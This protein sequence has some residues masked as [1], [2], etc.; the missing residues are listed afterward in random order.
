MYTGRF[1][2][3]PT[4]PLHIGSLLTALASWLW[5]HHAGGA[6]LVRIEDTDPPREPP[7]A[8]LSILASL[9]AHGLWHPTPVLWQSTRCDAYATA[10]RQL[11]DTGEAFYCTCSRQDLATGKHAVACAQSNELPTEPAAVRV[12]T[13]AG[14]A[15]FND[16]ILGR[17]D[18]PQSADSFVVQR[19]DG[20]YAYHLAVVVDDAFQQINHVVRGRDLLDSTPLH[21]RLQELLGLPRPAYAHLPLLLNSEGQKLS[22]Q[23]HATALDD[24]RPESNL[25]R[26]LQALNQ[27]Q[28]SQSCGVEALLEHAIAHWDTSRIPGHDIPE[29]SLPAEAPL[30]GS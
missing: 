9:R 5:A 21:I 10:V 12:R 13:P 3:S 23:N 26:C 4:G 14:T 11:L 24:S 29:A 1:A 8:A 16:E 17:V 27:L 19:R 2:P 22:K 15:S 25:R 28:P 20:L 6:W 30:L 7:G 18:I